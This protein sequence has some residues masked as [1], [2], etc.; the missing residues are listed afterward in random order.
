MIDSEKIKEMESQLEELHSR[1]DGDGL[2]EW[3]QMA[4][5]IYSWLIEDSE[6]PSLD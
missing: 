1:I 4:F 6:P 2:N 5:D 3:E